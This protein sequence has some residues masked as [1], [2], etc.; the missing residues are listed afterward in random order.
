[1]FDIDAKGQDVVYGA[2]NAEY[3]GG[4]PHVPAAVDQELEAAGAKMVMRSR[5]RP[6]DPFIAEGFLVAARGPRTQISAT[7]MEHGIVFGSKVEF[8]NAWNG[9]QVAV[10]A[11]Q[12]QQQPVYAQ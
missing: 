6:V 7:F 10:S 11:G 1:M 8:E 4:Q 5:V 3:R 9:T 12:G 2:V